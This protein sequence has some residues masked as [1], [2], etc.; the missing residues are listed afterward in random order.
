M[1]ETDNATDQNWWQL[2]RRAA[3]GEDLSAEESAVYEAAL[4][5]LDAGE[6]FPVDLAAMREVR[7]RLA[8]LD[9]E[10]ARLT[11]QREA[12]EAEITAL[13][14]RLDAPMRQ[15]LGLTGSDGR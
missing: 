10:R 4:A 7:A 12:L 2:H 14:A 5:R 11:R 6:T 15:A 8:V 1:N 13:E 9:A 3:S